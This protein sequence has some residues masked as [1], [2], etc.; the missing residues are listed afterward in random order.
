MA[1]FSF[2]LFLNPS[3]KKVTQALNALIDHIN[4]N[5]PQT[6]ASPTGTTDGAIITTVDSEWSTLEVPNATETFLMWD[7]TANEVAW[8]Y[9]RF[10][11]PASLLQS[12]KHVSNEYSGLLGKTLGSATCIAN[13]IYFTP[14]IA[15]STSIARY[16]KAIGTGNVTTDAGTLG[17]HALYKADR[18]TGMP[19]GAPLWESSSSGTSQ[20][21]AYYTY[22]VSPNIKTEPGALYW[23]ASKYDASVITMRFWGDTALG[24]MRWPD[25]GATWSSVAGAP[26]SYIGYWLYN[27]T[28]ATAWPSSF[29]W[30]TNGNFNADASK[31]YVAQGVQ[32]T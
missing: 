23:I 4:T 27:H 7:A 29:D 30:M 8:T 1:K 14:W 28:A 13:K 20:T 18:L 3:L 22:A 10:P 6:L 21:S 26:T 5:V 17:Y 9:P 31:D 32:L 24:N 12:P 2:P 16:I 25:S 19:D 15:P 11:I